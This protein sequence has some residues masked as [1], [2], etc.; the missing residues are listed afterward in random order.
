MIDREG[1]LQR[2]D[3]LFENRVLGKRDDRA[4]V[5]V[6]GD[7]RKL[8][9]AE[10]LRL[11]MAVPLR[12]A[13]RPGDNHGADHGLAVGVDDPHGEVQYLLGGAVDSWSSGRQRRSE[14]EDAQSKDQ[15]QGGGLRGH[16]LGQ[17]MRREQTSLKD[18]R[19]R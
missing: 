18:E 17:V 1:H 15:R 14:Q 9:A 10:T 16:G 5:G 13:K 19:W 2:E 6:G 3:E 4:S 11:P 7:A 8:E 12:A